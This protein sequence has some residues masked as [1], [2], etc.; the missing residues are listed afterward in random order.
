[1]KKL[2]NKVAVITGATSGMALATAKLF[3]EEGAY[4]FIT[5]RRQKELDEAVKTIGSNVTGV[6]CDSANLADLDRLFETIKT[7]KGHIDILY[8]SAGF[9]EFGNSIGSITEEHFDKNFNVNTKGTL[10]TIQKALPLFKDEGSII[11]TGTAVIS[12]VMEGMSVYSASKMALRVFARTWSVELKSRRIRVNVV[13]PGPINTAIIAHAPKETVDA[14][15]A[16][17]PFARLGQPEEI[18]AAVLFLA[19]DD[20]KFITGVELNVDGGMALV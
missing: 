5:G 16:G 1:M 4:V 9:G 15:V 12:K 8:A 7:E 11:M 2:E 18:A 17:V 3:V 20:S 19:S 14:I 10:F 6:Q 13:S